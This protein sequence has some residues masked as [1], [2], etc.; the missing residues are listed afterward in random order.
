MLTPTASTAAASRRR[1]EDQRRRPPLRGGL[2]VALMR[3]SA[4]RWSS[5]TAFTKRKKPM[6]EAKKTISRAATTPRV[7]PVKRSEIDKARAISASTGRRWVRNSVTTGLPAAAK[8]KHSA[9]ARTKAT[10]WF[11]V[12]AETA[13]PSA[14]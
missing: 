3:Q 11:L 8:T 5:T 9:T 10:T 12:S 14:R 4:F 13:A 2:V 1:A 6:K 7:K